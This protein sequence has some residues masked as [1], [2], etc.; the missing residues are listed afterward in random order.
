MRSFLNDIGKLVENRT[1]NN[2]NY[3][4]KKKKNGEQ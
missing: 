4:K 2:I 1:K 3:G